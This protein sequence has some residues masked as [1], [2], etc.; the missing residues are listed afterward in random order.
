MH[1]YQLNNFTFN[2]KN[3][4]DYCYIELSNNKEN[5]KNKLELNKLYENFDNLNDFK[6]MIERCFSIDFQKYTYNI[7]HNDEIVFINFNFNSELIKNNFSIK[8]I[9]QNKLA[10]KSLEKYLRNNFD[11][12]HNIHI[13]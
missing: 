7:Q 11:G 3:N 6:Q 2:F 12:I 1:S 8:A 13:Q 4:D 10:D 5:W 9:N